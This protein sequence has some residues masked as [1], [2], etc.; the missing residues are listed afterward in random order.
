MATRSYTT[1]RDTTRAEAD[2]T[3]VDR[4][5]PERPEGCCEAH[6][7]LAFGHPID[8]TASTGEIVRGVCVPQPSNDLV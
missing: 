5:V 7:S 3:L 8:A 4:W 2:G 6:R 1:S